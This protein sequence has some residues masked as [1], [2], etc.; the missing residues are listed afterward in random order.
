MNEDKATRYHRLKRWTSVIAL[1]WGIVLLAGLLATGA[2]IGLRGLAERWAVRVSAWPPLVRISSLSLYLAFIGAIN[3]VVAAPL[4]FYGGYRLEHRYDLSTETVGHWLIE[5]VKGLALGAGFGLVGVNL[6]YAALDRW[7]DGW[8]LPAGAGFSL[9][10]I[11]LANIAPVLL[12]PI[13]YRITPLTREALRARLVSLAGRAGVRVVNAFEWRV[14]DRTKKANAALTGL[15]RTRRILVSDTLL[16]EYS[17]EEIE[18]IL[19]HELGHHV[20]RDI[21]KGIAFETA[22]AFAG[23]YLAARLLVALAPVAGLRGP[24]DVAGLPLLLLGAGA[25][26]LVLVPIAN[27][28]SRLF[29]RSADRYALDLGRNAAAFI[30]AMRRLAAQNLAEQQPSRLARILFYSHPPVAERIEVARK[31]LA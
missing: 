14:S 2:S 4:G 10:T 13:F 7:P 22:L 26:S 16:A 18:M 20:H 17:D 27:A 9:I 1:A 6:L 25:V 19:A 15:G 3:E 21:W 29:E 8:W 28:L 12:L 23:F 24:S 31:R 5:R 11:L 30:S